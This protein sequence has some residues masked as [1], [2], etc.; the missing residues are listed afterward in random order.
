MFSS[1]DRIP[2][3]MKYPVG[4]NSKILASESQQVS[5]SHLLEEFVTLTTIVDFSNGLLTFRC[6]KT[7]PL[8]VVDIGE[9]EKP[10]MVTLPGNDGGIMSITVSP[11]A[12]FVFGANK[13]D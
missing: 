3:L 8:K 10:Q 6:R 9:V 7:D 11:G 4:V 2:S 5:L 1:F 13:S 12:S